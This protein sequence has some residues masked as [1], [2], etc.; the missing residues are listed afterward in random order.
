MGDVIQI[1]DLQAARERAHRRACDHQSIER[2]LG[3]MRENLAWAA[4]QLRTAPIDAHPELL[5]RI[6]KLAEMIRYGMMMLGEP[7][8]STADDDSKRRG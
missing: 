1:R 5:D 8:T 2:A 7:S 3:L 4:E 6:E